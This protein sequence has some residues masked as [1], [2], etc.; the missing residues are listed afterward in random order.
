MD[1]EK[2]TIS[3]HENMQPKLE[4]HSQTRK[5]RPPLRLPA[6]R[7]LQAERPVP[8]P[9]PIAPRLGN[10]TQGVNC[11]HDLPTLKPSKCVSDRPQKTTTIATR[12][13]QKQSMIRRCPPAFPRDIPQ[14]E[15]DH[16]AGLVPVLNRKDWTPSDS[17][18]VPLPA[19]TETHCPMNSPTVR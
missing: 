17:V 5:R 19:Q 1:N 11:W 7:F 4:C 3:E 16:C 14:R 9:A 12:L 8:A 10:R 2:K 13:S 15:L 6:E 18:N